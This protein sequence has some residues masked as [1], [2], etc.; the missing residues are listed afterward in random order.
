MRGDSPYASK[1]IENGALYEGGK[2]D[3]ITLLVSVL[4]DVDEGS[5]GERFAQSEI[6]YPLPYRD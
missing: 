2:P 1:C 4:D 5:E 6:R 3:D